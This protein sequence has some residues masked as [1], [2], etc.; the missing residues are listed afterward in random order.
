MQLILSNEQYQA[1]T[2]IPNGIRDQEL[3]MVQ[4]SDEDY[5]IICAIMK[6]FKEQ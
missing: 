1:Y 5:K 6:D 2:Y 3:H 4:Q